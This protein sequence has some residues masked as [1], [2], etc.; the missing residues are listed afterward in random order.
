MGA[1]AEGNL[2]VLHVHNT[3]SPQDRGGA[4]VDIFRVNADGKIV[5]LWGVI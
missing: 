1:I 3:T 4:M 2:V 5:E